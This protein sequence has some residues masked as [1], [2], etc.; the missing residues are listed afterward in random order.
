[1]AFNEILA[2]PN[3]AITGSMKSD[4]ASSNGE[5]TFHKRDCAS[6]EQSENLLEQTKKAIDFS[7]YFYQQSPIL[8]NIDS[9]D[10]GSADGTGSKVQSSKKPV[11]L[12]IYYNNNIKTQN[13]GEDKENT[14]SRKKPF[15]EV[16]DS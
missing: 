14:D 8:V 5:F 15:P 3:I 1:M 16:G 4:I 2:G 6:A 10:S 9:K 7:G 11:S 13:T 12:R